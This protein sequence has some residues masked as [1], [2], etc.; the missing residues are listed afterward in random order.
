MLECL[1]VY[2]QCDCT[3]CELQGTGQD[4]H[5]CLVFP[6]CSFKW[7]IAVELGVVNTCWLWP[8]TEVYIPIFIYAVGM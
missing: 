3:V 8:N 1:H 6:L 4:K 5:T 7:Y 2:I